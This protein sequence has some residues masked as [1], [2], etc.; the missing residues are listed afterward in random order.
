[1]NFSKF[2]RTPFSYRTPQVAASGCYF[3]LPD[4]HTYMC[5]SEEIL[6]QNILHTYETDEPVQ[7]EFIVEEFPVFSIVRFGLTLIF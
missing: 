1:M 2:L 6:V 7:L 3:L 5:V 4:T